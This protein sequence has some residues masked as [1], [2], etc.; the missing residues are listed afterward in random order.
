MMQ[1][2]QIRTLARDAGVRPGNLGK[3]AL[4]RTI[5]R[6]EGNFDCF[7]TAYDGVCDQTDC[8]WREDCFALAKKG[9]RSNG[10]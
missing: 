9:G 3:V 5:Q 6:R 1:I 4:V 7:A 10:G 8:R 2:Q